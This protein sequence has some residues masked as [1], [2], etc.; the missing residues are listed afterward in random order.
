MVRLVSFCSV[1]SSGATQLLCGSRAGA[2]QRRTLNHV[3]RK[4]AAAAAAR[5]HRFF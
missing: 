2:T 1:F 4:T 3:K 5:S